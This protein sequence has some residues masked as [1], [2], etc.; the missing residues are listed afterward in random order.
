MGNL[1]GDCEDDDDG[2][3][4]VVLLPNNAVKGYVIVSKIKDHMEKGFSIDDFEG[5]VVLDRNED[6]DDDDDDDDDE[7]SSR[8]IPNSDWVNGNVYS[9]EDNDS[10]IDGT[11][12]GTD[13]DDN[14][15][16]DFVVPID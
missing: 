9:D 12:F 10:V 14:V 11:F 13:E 8:G 3:V 5:I 4:V 15:L 2:V 7:V 6:D 1:V 16:V